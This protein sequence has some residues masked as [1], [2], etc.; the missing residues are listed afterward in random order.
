MLSDRREQAE[1][2]LLDVERENQRLQAAVSMETIRG[3]AYKTSFDRNVE[4]RTQ[5][6]VEESE[7]V[8]TLESQVEEQNQ[9]LQD[10]QL[11]VDRQTADHGILSSRADES[12]GRVAEM[13]AELTVATTKRDEQESRRLQIEADLEAAGASLAELQRDCSALRQ[14]L[15]RSRGQTRQAVRDRDIL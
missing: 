6:N 10:L 4:Q 13:T 3:E 8:A 1:Q 2:R 11:V 12:E 14:E 9:R 15:D 5:D 7:V